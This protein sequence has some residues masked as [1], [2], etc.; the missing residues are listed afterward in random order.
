MAERQG[1]ERASSVASSQPS[2]SFYV[3]PGLRFEGVLA[4]RH[5]ITGA[6]GP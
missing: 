6:P 3:Q 2:V 1:M 4:L 5:H